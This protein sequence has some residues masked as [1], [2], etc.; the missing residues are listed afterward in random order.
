MNRYLKI[1]VALAFVLAF[2]QTA[3]A[4]LVKNGGF[5]DGN[6]TGWTVSKALFG[7]DL[8]IVNFWS[9]SGQYAAAF[10]ATGGLDDTITQT[11][12]TTRGQSYIFSFWLAHEGTDN[13]N[14]FYAIW[15]GNTVLSFIYGKT[16][17]SFHYTEY[18]YI[19]TATGASTAISFSGQENPSWYVLDDVSVTPDAVVVPLPGAILL[20]GSGLVGLAGWRFRKG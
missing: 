4:D 16:N 14:D 2:V 13:Q 8:S 11:I 15:N 17:N 20:L 9:H 10:G 18:S 12:A 1:F 19:V 7:S 5:E 3:G 6:F